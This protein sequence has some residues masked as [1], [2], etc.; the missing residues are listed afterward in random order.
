MKKNILL[1]ILI[2]ILFPTITADIISL[3]SGGSEEITISSGANIEQFFF[4]SPSTCTNLGYNCGSWSD[5]CGGTLN[6]GTCA[7]GYTCSSGICTIITTGDDGGSSGGTSTPT[8]KI[9]ITPPEITLTMVINTA[10]NQIIEIKN[11][12]TNQQTIS[13]SQSKLNNLVFLNETSITLMG[14][15]TK[16][17]NARFAAPS[18]PGIYTGKILIGN[19]QILVTL[20]VKTKLLLFDSNIIV[21]NE[22]YRVPQGD[23]L[24][25]QVTLIPLGD[26]ERLDV[27]L[28]YEIKDYDGKIY[29]TQSETLLVDKEINFKRDFGTGILPLGQY[30]IGLELIYPNGVAPSSAHFEIIKKIPIDF[31]NLIFYLIISILIIAILI[32]IILIT[33]KKKIV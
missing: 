18:E 27:T 20:N 4:C 5:N 29:L 17:I 10:I 11:L 6:C 1:L 28:N 25:T 16:N 8:A 24:K 32:V 15:E 2:F 30:V 13:L 22:N 23:K 19:K 9:T 7:S 31:G 26:E 12:R 33:K 21:L 14:G 3:N